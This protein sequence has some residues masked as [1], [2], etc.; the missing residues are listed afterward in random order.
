MGGAES[1][2]T[3]ERVP[4]QEG[5]VVIVTG[6]N[7]GVGLEAAKVLFARGAKVVIAGRSEERIRKAVDDIKALEG[8]GEVE[9]HKLDLADL[10]SVR[11]F[12]DWFSGA[13]SVEWDEERC[14]EWGFSNMCTGGG[15]G[16]EG[17]GRET[18]VMVGS[19]SPDESARSQVRSLGRAAQQ[20][21]RDGHQ[22]S[23]GDQG[24][25]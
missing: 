7:S 17:S 24:R 10:A 14:L 19:T 4:A 21:R 18:V 15:G 5:R 9:A 8:S 1:R 11:D 20:R 16:E 23:G 3:A 25:L 2:W 13:C 12:A 22:P 6:G